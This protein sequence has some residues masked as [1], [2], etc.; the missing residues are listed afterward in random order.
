MTPTADT[1]PGAVSSTLVVGTVSRLL[2]GT[3]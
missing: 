3:R 2:T 1:W